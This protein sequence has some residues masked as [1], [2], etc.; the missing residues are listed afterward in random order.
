MMSFIVRDILQAV[1]DKPKAKTAL[2]DIKL[3]MRGGSILLT[4]PPQLGD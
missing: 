1:G 2:D 4:S 3:A